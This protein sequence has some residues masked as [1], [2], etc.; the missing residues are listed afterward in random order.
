MPAEGKPSAGRRAWGWAKELVLVIV[1]ALLLS[2]VIK[3]FFFQSFYIPSES[4]EPT[5][6]KGDRILVT[7]WRP[8]PLALRRGDVVVFKDPANWLGRATVDESGLHR[9]AKDVLTWTGLLPEDA[10]EHLVKRVV[11]LPGDVVEC[12]D[13]DGQVT[14]NGEALDEEYIAEGSRACGT[15]FRVE[16]PE[17]YIW[18]MGDNRDDSADSRA[19]MGDPGGGT[20]P[21]DNIVGTTFAVVWPFD[22]FGGVGNPW[23]DDA[24]STDD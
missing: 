12:T 20:V 1:S 17:D 14:V 2:L 6:I 24:P 16:V 9:V 4:M 15:E 3:T 22:R 10:G 19:H 8:D 11:G 21:M 7:K 18:V 5:L 13:P 23:G